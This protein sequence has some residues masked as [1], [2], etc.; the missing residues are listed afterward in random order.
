MDVLREAVW[1]IGPQIL[2]GPKGRQMIGQWLK[3]VPPE[4]LLEALLAAYKNRVA[5]PIS[6]IQACVQS[7]PKAVKEDRVDGEGEK[8]KM[9][10][11]GWHEK[12]IWPP[13]AG[14]KPG[15]EGCQCPSQYLIGN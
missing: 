1:F 12:K 10:A 5:E 3:I 14:P 6:Y 15:E 7:A 9:R 4:A 13:L 8:W 2:Q 11:K